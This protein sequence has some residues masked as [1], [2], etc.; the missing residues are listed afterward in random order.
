MNKDLTAY[1]K[2]YKVFEPEFCSDVVS[3]LEKADWHEH[4]FN[5][6]GTDKNVSYENEL[7]VSHYEAPKRLEINERLWH[8]I[9]KYVSELEFDEWFNG[10]SGYTGIRFNKYD[11]NTQ[12]K[13]HC[14]HIQTI[15]DGERKGIPVLTL[16]GA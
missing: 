16:I 10:W 13:I 8:V 6:A 2:I 3:S 1:V 14:D 4:A 11:I 15:F 5:I 12:M 7:S 9:Q